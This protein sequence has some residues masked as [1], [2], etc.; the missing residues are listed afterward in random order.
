MKGHM[1]GIIFKSQVIIISRDDGREAQ[2]CFRGEALSSL[3]LC[4]QQSDGAIVPNT[5]VKRF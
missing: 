2:L 3:R 4:S 5:A 1:Q